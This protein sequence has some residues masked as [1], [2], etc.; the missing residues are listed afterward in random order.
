MRDVCAYEGGQGES[1]FAPLAA[2]GI[3]H[4]GLH[5]ER[6]GRYG[7]STRQVAHFAHP[8]TLSS[9]LCLGQGGESMDWRRGMEI[10][11]HSIDQYIR[12]GWSP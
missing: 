7:V 11:I 8:I 4:C 3:L 5:C 1:Y 10:D 6:G 12:K 2:S 9:R